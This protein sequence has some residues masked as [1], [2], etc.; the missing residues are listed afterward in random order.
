MDSTAWRHRERFTPVCAGT[1]RSAS[2]VGPFLRHA[3]HRRTAQGVAATTSVLQESA[4]LAPAERVSVRPLIVAPFE[5]TADWSQET[6]NG[7]MGAQVEALR[8]AVCP[9]HQDLCLG[10][11]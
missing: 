2:G 3:L 4:V 7:H 8:V 10:S 6:A 11:V 9:I 1:W 5:A